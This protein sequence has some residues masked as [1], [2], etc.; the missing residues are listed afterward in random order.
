MAAA[1]IETPPGLWYDEGVKQHAAADLLLSAAVGPLGLPGIRSTE[2]RRHLIALICD[3]RRPFRAADLVAPAHELGI[4]RATVFRLLDRLV[5]I[6]FLERRSGPEG[7]WIYSPPQA[8]FQS[9]HLICVA[10]RKVEPL[11]PV[12]VGEATRAAARDH[13]FDIIAQRV[14]IFGR[15][16]DCRRAG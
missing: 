14:N 10:C 16:R 2:P 6:G 7:C 9:Q 15:C 11:N 8:S 5:A 12:E 3:Q 4:S 13:D 1:F